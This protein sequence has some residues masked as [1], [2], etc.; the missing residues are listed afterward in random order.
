[1]YG[2]HEDELKQ[3]SKD[4]SLVQALID[5]G[6]ITMEQARQHPLR[7]VL[8]QCLGGGLEEELFKPS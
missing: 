1:V 2:V 4:Q 3:I 5:E 8:L 7:G 6:T